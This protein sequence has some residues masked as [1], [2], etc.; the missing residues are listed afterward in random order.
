MPGMFEYRAKDRTGHDINGVLIA[1]NESAVAA[2]VRSQGQYPIKIRRQR[3]KLSGLRVSLTPVTAH[4]LAIFCRQ[5]ATMLDAG[6]PILICLKILTEQT[7][8]PA[9]KDAIKGLLASVQAGETLAGSMEQH[10]RIF[11]G[12]MINMIRAGEVGGVL[13]EILN[14]LAQHYEKRT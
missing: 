10:F 12:I 1:E 5:F 14:R 9:L 2:Y 6:L 4:D 11:P 3:Q 7:H 8:S 13:D